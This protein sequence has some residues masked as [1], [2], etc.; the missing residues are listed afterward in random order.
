MSYSKLSKNMNETKIEGNDSENIDTVEE[1]QAPENETLEQKA[2]RLEN[3][4]KQLFARAKKA[5]GFELVD[6]KWIKKS[7]PETK[8]EPKNDA[9]VDTSKLSQTDVIAIIKN[10]VPEEDIEEIADYAKLKKITFAEA[11]K[12]TVVKTLLSDKAE[13]RRVAEGTS[14]GAG[15][16]GNA[17]L[18]DE[19]L[20][21]DAE[22]GK[23][24]EK[25]ED[26]QRLVRLQRAKKK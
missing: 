1:A 22:A 4:N 5:E 20:L 6:G 9:T 12:T 23:F 26:I 19:A 14:T 10:N 7:K 18:S 24:P 11:L 25:D 16:R 3:S 17:K 8:L 15:K 13:Q 2:E 21:A